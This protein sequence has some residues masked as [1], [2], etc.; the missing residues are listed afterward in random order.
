MDPSTPPGRAPME[1]AT[2]HNHDPRSG[3]V[4]VDR[5]QMP[6]G[7]VNAVIRPPSG[8]RLVV[9]LAG[10][11][12]RYVVVPASH[13]S[14]VVE[15]PFG[16]ATRIVS[17]SLRH[18]ILGGTVY[19]RE[20]GRLVPQGSRA[21]QVRFP[22]PSGW[23]AADNQSQA[24]VRAGLAEAVLTAGEPVDIDAWHGV[25]HLHGRISTDAGAIEAL[26][27]AHG[28]S[29]VWHAVTTVISDE[30]LRMRLRRHVQRSEVAASVASISVNRGDGLVTPF[31]DANLDD[32]ILSD[33]HVGTPGLTT[34]TLGSPRPRER[35]TGRIG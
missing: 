4:V 22:P 10:I 1:A 31:E 16:P 34:L 18:D 23:E 5:E 24:E 28:A 13:L 14:G 30:A 29:G 19:R 3:D 25:I 33:W 9:A 26:R 2:H 11:R 8:V 32:A 15:P 7:I 20:M 27:I 35:V 17:S 6:V 12:D 21:E